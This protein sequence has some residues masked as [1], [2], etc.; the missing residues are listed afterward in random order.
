M[1]YEK[2]FQKDFDEI[3]KSK[4]KNIKHLLTDVTHFLTFVIPGRQPYWP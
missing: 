4:N 1:I 2:Y 3:V